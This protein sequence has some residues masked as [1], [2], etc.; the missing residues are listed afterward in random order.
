MR[1]G[2]WSAGT[3]GMSRQDVVIAVRPRAE[4]V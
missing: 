4:I 1:Y 2:K 3:D